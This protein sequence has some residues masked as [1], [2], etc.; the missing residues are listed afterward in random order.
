MQNF[1]LLYSF[2]VSLFLESTEALLFTY[3]TITHFLGT[4]LPTSKIEFSQLLPC[5]TFRMEHSGEMNN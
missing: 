3:A 4:H 2:T 1:T 5:V